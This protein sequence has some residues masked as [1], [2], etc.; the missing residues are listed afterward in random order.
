MNQQE[1]TSTH[2]LTYQPLTYQPL[3]HDHLSESGRHPVNLTHLILGIAF[4][5]FAGIW[6]AI[7]GEVVPTE[8]LRWLLPVPWLLAGSAG[9]VAIALSRL[10]HSHRDIGLVSDDAVDT[11]GQE[12]P[13]LSGEVSER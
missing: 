10:R 1:S 4:L 2:P 9:L 8:D 12:R 5:G 11:G 7:A 13:D 6:A 3:A